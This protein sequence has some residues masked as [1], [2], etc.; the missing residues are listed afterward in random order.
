MITGPDKD[1]WGRGQGVGVQWTHTLLTQNEL[2]RPV[3]I[4]V[5][6]ARDKTIISLIRIIGVFQ[7]L[8]AETGV[9][10][11]SNSIIS[12]YLLSAWLQLA[13]KCVQLTLFY[14]SFSGTAIDSKK[15]LTSIHKS[16]M[17]V[18]TI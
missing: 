7:T 15:G 6:N 10:I 13:R 18:S 14:M 11:M 8:D 17:K 3:K 12:G 4:N 16:I 2:S 1:N 9:W 5:D